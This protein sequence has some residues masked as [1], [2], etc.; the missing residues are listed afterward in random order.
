MKQTSVWVLI[1]DASGARLLQTHRLEA[2]GGFHQIA[3]FHN[4]EL[5]ADHAS[6]HNKP[7]RSF[8]SAGTGQRHAIEPHSDPAKAIKMKFADRLAHELNQAALA[9]K[10]ERLVIAAP[11]AMLGEIRAALDSHAAPKL[12]MS[13]HKDLMHVPLDQMAPH[14]SER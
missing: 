1:A 2:D 5:E 13:V 12:F 7:G 14:F 9:G 11:P 3:T 6:R 8:D 4:D 10:F